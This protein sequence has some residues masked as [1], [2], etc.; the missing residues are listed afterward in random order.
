M[1]VVTT[2]PNVAMMFDPCSKRKRLGGCAVGF[3]SMIKEALP[4]HKVIVSAA[5]SIPGSGDGAG[6]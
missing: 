2:E 5:S 6:S 3:S 4:I 1:S